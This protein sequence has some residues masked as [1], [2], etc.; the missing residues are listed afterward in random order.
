M[1]DR[2]HPDMRARLLLRSRTGVTT[3]AISAGFMLT[4]MSPVSRGRKKK[5]K[6]GKPT[7]PR[8]A[9]NTVPSPFAG[10]HLPRPGWF[11]ASIKNV[12]AGADAALSAGSP[13]ELEQVVSELLGAGLEKT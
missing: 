7:N 11:D 5:P 12:M 4:A 1:N 10:T 3:I 6:Q 8:P 9:R 2:Q 13:R